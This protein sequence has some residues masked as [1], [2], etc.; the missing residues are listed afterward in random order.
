MA[1]GAD[2]SSDQIGSLVLIG[3][4]IFFLP[5][6]AMM[7]VYFARRRRTART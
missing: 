1:G 5:L 3:W 7:A 6:A 2:G 4:S